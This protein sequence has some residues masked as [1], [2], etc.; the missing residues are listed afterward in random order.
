MAISKGETL[1]R[2]WSR[3]VGW[4]GGL[5][6]GL[7]GIG[8]PVQGQSQSSTLP[9]CG[10]PEAIAGEQ[11]ALSLPGQF[12]GL[13]PEQ[14][15][16]YLYSEAED[17]TRYFDWLG[18]EQARFE[19]TLMIEYSGT[20]DYEV[21]EL[22]E[23]TGTSPYLIS[24]SWSTND[25]TSHIYTKTGEEIGSFVDFQVF[26]PDYQRVITSN[27]D[28]DTTRIL[29]LNGQ[30][31]VSL[32]GYFDAYLSRELLQREV[33]AIAT[34]SKSQ[35][36]YSIFSL[37]GTLQ[38]SLQG[39][40]EHL[41]DGLLVYEWDN[42][43]S[44]ARWVDAQGQE[45]ITYIGQD[46]QGF[47]ADGQ[48]FLLYN[49]R[50]RLLRRYTLDGTV[51]A[52]YPGRLITFFNGEAG[53]VTYDYST[54]TYHIFHADGTEQ[55]RTQEQ[56]EGFI[57]EET[58]LVTVRTDSDE[59]ATTYFRRL[60]GTEIVS[61]EGAIYGFSG[62]GQNFV[63]YNSQTGQKSLYNFAGELL[64]Q[65]SDESYIFTP[66]DT[67]Y[68]TFNWNAVGSRLFTLRGEKIATFPGTFVDF[69][70]DGQG[71]FIYSPSGGNMRVYSLS[72]QPQL[73]LGIG[74]LVGL[75][76]DEQSVILS[77]YEGDGT[78]TITDLESGD[79]RVF[80]GLLFSVLYQS[81]LSEQ[82]VLITY[83]P[84]S[85]RTLFHCLPPQI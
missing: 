63:T 43:D 45:K 75:T 38:Y 35:T 7:I 78:T 26:T 10:N 65:F 66:D 37:D 12:W 31:I 41:Q 1:M 20:Y 11:A 69:T 70:P 81:L 60:D 19:G 64:S 52:E 28:E 18:R 9:I 39:N 82:G 40:I 73:E 57:Q 5:C 58:V 23:Y 46:F 85:N 14:Q 79:R 68:I 3:L 56:F 61:I 71:L 17:I 33:P 76:P 62:N 83:L 2:N 13:A 49:D 32:P 55:F 16:L 29:D 30:E 25:V 51:K 34:F 4:T 74:D 53:I 24:T 48:E 42:R 15:G 44:N 8:M 72:G 80:S 22:V 59:T 67:G 36:T 6:I 27:Y 21:G 47:M 84:T 54:E 50:D 77:D